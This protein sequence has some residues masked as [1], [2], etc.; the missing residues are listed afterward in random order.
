MRGFF[1]YILL[2]ATH[3]RV[4]GRLRLISL[5]RPKFWGEGNAKY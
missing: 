3:V 5:T 2:S 1:Y 4:L